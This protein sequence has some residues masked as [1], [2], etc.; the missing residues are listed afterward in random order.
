MA[1]PR[2]PGVGGGCSLGLQQVV[3]LDGRAENH[4]AAAV[5][6]AVDRRP[7]QVVAPRRTGAGAEADVDQRA[8]LQDVRE[9][10]AP[11]AVDD[12]PVGLVEPPEPD[13]A[14]PS[15]SGSSR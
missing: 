4:G 3:V 11:G 13:S 9:Q 14:A 2:L 5:V 12:R 1:T 7:V 8:V 10:G 6:G 15:R